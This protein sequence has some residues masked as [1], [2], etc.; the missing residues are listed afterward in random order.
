MGLLHAIGDYFSAQP[1]AMLI[2]ATIVAWLV[3][4]RFYNY[5]YLIEG[6]ARI[7]GS[8]ESVEDLSSGKTAENILAAPPFAAMSALVYNNVKSTGLRGVITDDG[9]FDFSSSLEGWEEI[10]LPE[11]M[12]KM[13]QTDS[14][15]QAWP[16]GDLVY[17]IWI[18]KLGED[19]AELAIA[20]R[21]THTWGDWWSNARWITRFLAPGWDQ[22]DLTQTVARYVE[23]DL[24]QDLPQLSG[25]T[26]EI[27]AT[28]HSLGGGLAQQA[29]YAAVSIKRVYSFNGSSITGFYS[30]KENR[31]ESKKG[32]RILR[33][34]ERGEVLAYLRA[35]MRIIF[36]VV[37][38]DPK[39][40]E[41]TYNFGDGNLVKQHSMAVLASQLQHLH[42]GKSST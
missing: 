8:L 21:G 14:G 33:I 36:P 12:P 4:V 23:S 40:L 9:K 13:P 41:V 25:K 2:W 37:E 29:G 5:K 11:N 26:V 34:G 24:I 7:A 10:K 42:E 17:G 20:F 30:V 15:R 31:N 27:V 32:M 38:K 1:W 22:Y 18:K 19:R 3:G 6:S 28:G 39:I 35:F 16:D